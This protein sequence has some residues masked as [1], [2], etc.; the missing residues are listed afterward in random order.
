MTSTRAA[1]VFEARTVEKLEA[2]LPKMTSLLSEGT[3]LLVCWMSVA[4]DV[5]CVR[6]ESIKAALL[7]RKRTASESAES[8]D[9]AKRVRA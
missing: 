5:T 6:Q 8:S 4:L 1:P 2:L 7:S 3:E 9:G